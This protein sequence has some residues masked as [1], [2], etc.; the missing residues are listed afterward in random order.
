MN[1]SNYNTTNRAAQWAAEAAEFERVERLAIEELQNEARAIEAED[2]INEYYDVRDFY[3]EAAKTAPIDSVAQRNLL[4]K[5]W[6][7][8]DMAFRWGQYRYSL[9]NPSRSVIRERM[10]EI[11]QRE[12]A[13]YSR[14]DQIA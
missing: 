7:A 12:D 2:I 13:M 8:E 11:R 1:N 6:A 5:A 9:M 10:S 4:S 3:F 14:M